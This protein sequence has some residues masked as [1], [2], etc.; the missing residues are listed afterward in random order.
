MSLLTPRGSL[1]RKKLKFTHLTLSNPDFRDVIE[2]CL[3]DVSLPRLQSG[4]D[5]PSMTLR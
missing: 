3:A 2:V 1:M 4:R 5:Y